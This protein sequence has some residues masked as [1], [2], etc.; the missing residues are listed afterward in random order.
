MRKAFRA[1]LVASL[2]LLS[3]DAASAQAAKSMSVVQ[4]AGLNACDLNQDGAVNIFDIQL[5]VNMALGTVP[6]TA[7]VTSASVCDMVLVQRV[8]NAALTGNCLT[9]L[10]IHGVTSTWTASTSANVTGYNVYRGT[11]TG[12]PY[13]KINAFPVAATS[14]TDTP[15]QSGQTYYYVVTAVDSNNRE[16]AYSNQAVAIIPVP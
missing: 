16:S 2:P 9:G 1:A 4:S 11:Q 6:C 14:Y 13:A 5:A 15:V 3:S 10:A 7:N 12:G 8:T